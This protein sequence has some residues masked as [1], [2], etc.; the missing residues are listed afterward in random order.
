M[1]RITNSQL[2]VLYKGRSH[3]IDFNLSLETRIQDFTL[4][5]IG[6]SLAVCC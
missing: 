5:Y 2:E 6:S 1:H 3:K 4:K